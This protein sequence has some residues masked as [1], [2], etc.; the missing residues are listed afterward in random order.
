MNAYITDFNKTLIA[1]RLWGMAR[2]F[3]KDREKLHEVAKQYRH[4]LIR[5][6]MCK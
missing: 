3:R 2:Q 6:Q 4:E 5:Y 1:L